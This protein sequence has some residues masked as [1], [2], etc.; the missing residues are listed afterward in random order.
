MENYFLKGQY[1][2]CPFNLKLQFMVYDIGLGFGTS[3]DIQ[4]LDFPIQSPPLSSPTSQNVTTQHSKPSIL[5]NVVSVFTGKDQNGNAKTFD[6]GSIIKLPSVS[7]KADNSQWW[8]IAL[9]LS[10]TGFVIY[11]ST[12]K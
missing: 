3:D 2:Y 1:L 4:G 7:V 11:H 6:L 5:E 9:I 12:K 8:I 10:V